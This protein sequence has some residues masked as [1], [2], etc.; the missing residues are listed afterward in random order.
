M[1]LREHVRQWAAVSDGLFWAVPSASPA[2]SPALV[3]WADVVA[4]GTGEEWRVLPARRKPAARALEKLLRVPAHAPAPNVEVSTVR[5]PQMLL[6]FVVGNC[7]NVGKSS[8]SHDRSSS[9]GGTADG[10]GAAG[11]AKPKQQNPCLIS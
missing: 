4:G 6:C 11:Q 9:R 1:L 2:A 8:S 3:R 7:R 10:S 5:Q